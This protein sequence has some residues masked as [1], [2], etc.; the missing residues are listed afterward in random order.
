MA[1]ETSVEVAPAVSPSGKK[2]KAPK[3]AAA[4]KPRV[5]PTHPKTSE[6]VNKAI[7]DLKERGGSSLQAIKKFVAANY[8]VD[9]EKLAPFIRRYLKSAVTSGALVQTKGKGASG[10]FKL[11]GSAKGEKAVAK[12]LRV[13]K[14]SGEKKVKKAASPKK[15]ASTAAKKAV[16]AKK[17]S[18][19]KKKAASPKKA[20]VKKSAPK[21]KSTKASSKSAGTKPKVPKPKKTGSPKKAAPKKTAAKKK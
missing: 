8:K 2:A 12:K 9:A 1:E 3:S 5:K 13:K 7:K 20:A 14:A 16:A 11:P 18:G 4:K 19:E 15:K 21:Q 10:S 6:M 17:P